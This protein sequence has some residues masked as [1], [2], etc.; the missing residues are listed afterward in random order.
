MAR[1]PDKP[2]PVEKELPPRPI[3][4]FANTESPSKDGR[5]LIDALERPLRLSPGTPAE[6]EWPTL[7]PARQPL[8]SPITSADPVD[9]NTSGLDSD[10]D[11]GLKIYTYL[12]NPNLKS[13]WSVD[14]PET[15]SS[16]TATFSNHGVS[17]HWPSLTSLRENSLR[18]PTMSGHSLEIDN[19]RPRSISMTD[20]TSKATASTLETSEFN[21]STELT[22]ESTDTQSRA[23]SPPSCSF[24][25][26]RIANRR[27]SLPGT[28]TLQN[29]LHQNK[30]HS[31]HHATASRIPIY[32]PRKT[33]NLVDIKP[34]R[35][36]VPSVIE[37]GSMPTFGGRRLDS[38]A[39]LAALDKDP[40]AR[41][42][43]SDRTLRQ[44]NPNECGLATKVSIANMKNQ[45]RVLMRAPSPAGSIQNNNAR[46]SQRYPRNPSIASAGTAR[47][48]SN[49]RMRNLSGQL[50]SSSFPGSTLVIHDEADNVLFGC[51]QGRMT[52]QDAAF[53]EPNRHAQRHVPPSH[54][55]VR[56]PRHMEDIN[57]RSPVLE[58]PRVQCMKRLPPALQRDQQNQHEIDTTLSLLEGTPPSVTP[59]PDDFLAFANAYGNKVRP[60]VE[61][62]VSEVDVGVAHDGNSSGALTPEK[63]RETAAAAQR[64]VDHGGNSPHAC[65]VGNDREAG[66]SP[67]ERMPSYMHSTPASQARRVSRM[68]S[69]EV[70]QTTYPSRMSSNAPRYDGTIKGRTPSPLQHYH[71]TP[72]LHALPM[73]SHQSN[74]NLVQPDSKSKR[75]P[76]SESKSRLF[77][78]FKGFFTSKRDNIGH[79]AYAADVKRPSKQSRKANIKTCGDAS[80]QKS[81]GTIAEPVSPLPETGQSRPELRSLHD[82]RADDLA[83]VV[84]ATHALIT[85]AGNEG[86]DVKRER[87]VSLAKVMMDTISNSREA[88]RSMIVAQQA[89]ASAKISYEM[90]QQSVLEMGRLITTSKG[91]MASVLKKIAVKSGH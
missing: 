4:T 6:V 34:P 57:E 16:P 3:A 87:L 32:D 59:T 50:L 53:N 27:S 51:A 82:R 48:R 52:N 56:D 73:I 46:V 90:T 45:V 72:K 79:N 88:E 84:G 64:Y 29:D 47:D 7:S 35:T 18:V 42:Q 70:K 38:P 19:V 39:D 80:E 76:R 49:S 71:S 40:R 11:P 12:P 1:N 77:N 25:Q 78:N 30:S 2:L 23:H 43:L 65:Q 33:P 15:P 74:L 61:A 83:A 22:Q 8:S 10:L 41:R 81:L 44:T 67:S 86:D 21:D 14:T 36:P 60:R 24:S 17:S 85:E 37:G 69:R 62:P 91:S 9:K 75:R 26:P 58:T 31:R 89:A 55:Q 20:R 66:Y 28:P 13:H 63:L 5:M 54:D 68:P